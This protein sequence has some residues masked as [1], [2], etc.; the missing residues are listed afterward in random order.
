MQKS[1][2][3]KCDEHREKIVSRTASISPISP[4]NDISE[5]NI[6]AHFAEIHNTTISFYLPTYSH[7]LSI[8]IVSFKEYQYHPNHYCA[9]LI[10]FLT[11]TMLCMITQLSTISLSTGRKSEDRRYDL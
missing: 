1:R 9:I 7:P 10:L 2:E 8:K 4:Y 5:L 11:P 6:I 3:T